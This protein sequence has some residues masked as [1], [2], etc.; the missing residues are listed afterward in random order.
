MSREVRRV[1]LDFDFPLGETWSGYLTDEFDF[2]PC[3]DCAY[4]ELPTIMSQLFPDRRG[5]RQPSTGMTREAYAI[6]Q[7]FYPHMIGGPMAKLL[8]WGDKLGQ[9][10]VDHLVAKRR[11]GWADRWACWD[12]IELTV[13]R[14]AEDGHEIRYEFVRNDRPGPTAAEVNVGQRKDGPGWGHDAINRMMLVEFRCQQLGITIECP[15]CDGH[16]DLA[17]DEQRQA[18]KEWQGTEPPVGEGYQLWQT[19]SEGGPVSPVFAT[20][21]E[22]A[23][24]II[25]SG[26]DLHGANVSYERL[27]AWIIKGGQSVG[28][29]VYIPERGIVSGVE[30]AADQ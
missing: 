18:A 13:P 10:E 2:P 29:F 7:T 25:A 23:D 17:T 16:G 24:W 4:E 6:A 20:P 21:G 30:A 12:R 19:V 1:P 15:T 9:A 11:L 27:I 5:S 14:I 26:K 22:L 3:P 8:A 28:S